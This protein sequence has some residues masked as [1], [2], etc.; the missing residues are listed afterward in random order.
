M[1]VEG[2]DF[3][4]K[5]GELDVEIDSKFGVIKY[6]ISFRV[7]KLSRRMDALRWGYMYA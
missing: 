3:T 7:T 6:V 2:D 4:G 1:N 5:S